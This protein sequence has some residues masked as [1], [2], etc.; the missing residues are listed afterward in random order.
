MHVPL[1]PVVKNFS[2]QSVDRDWGAA[3]AEAMAGM[4]RE[5]VS[6]LMAEISRSGRTFSAWVVMVVMKLI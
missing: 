2:S 3:L 6:K 5:I 4:A 1:I